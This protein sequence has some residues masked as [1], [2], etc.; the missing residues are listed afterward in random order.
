MAKEEAIRETITLNLIQIKK[1]E[2]ESLSSLRDLIWRKN[3]K[4]SSS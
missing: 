2:P 1:T 3:L 4:V